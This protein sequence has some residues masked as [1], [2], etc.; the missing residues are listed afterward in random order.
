LFTLS[1]VDG[2]KARAHRL[3]EGETIIGR[4]P[5][6]ELVIAA[7]LMSR[8]HARV[9]VAKGKVFVKDAGSTYGTIVDG[10]PLKGEREL[11]P[12]DIFSIAQI[13]VRLEGDVEESEVLSEG[14]QLL[15]D[16][17][18]ILVR[19]DRP[20]AFAQPVATTPAPVEPAAAAPA[21]AAAPS[22]PAPAA[23]SPSP[24]PAGPERRKVDR[25]RRK[26]R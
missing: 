1:F 23:A 3:R 4:A 20:A 12:G 18:T 6:C 21:P 24:A 10:A 13:E 7:P 25:R 19:V 5:T 16:S 11:H 8:E 26:Q 15:D 9:R 14:H 22:S 2:G 17:S